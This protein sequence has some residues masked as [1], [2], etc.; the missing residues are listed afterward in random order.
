MAQQMNTMNRLS[1]LFIVE[2]ESAASTLRQALHKPSQQ[3]LALQGKLINCAKASPAKILANQSCQKVFQTLDCGIGSNCNP[4]NL[5]FT[6]ILILMDPDIDGAHAQVLILRLFD[7]YLRPLIDKGLISII[8]PPLFRIAGLN[9][10]I[11]YAWS[12]QQCEQIIANIT[13]KAGIEI[14]RFK[15]VAQFTAAECVILLLDPATRQQTN[16]VN[17]QDT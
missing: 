8:N 14:T 17:H 4:N 11:Q 3:V 12:E 7:N 5:S 1:E 15:G 10:A 6:R 2:G 16:L 13:Q 9:S